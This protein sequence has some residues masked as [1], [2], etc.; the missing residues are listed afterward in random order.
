M[1][2]RNVLRVNRTESLSGSGSFSDSRLECSPRLV[3]PLSDER[4]SETQGARTPT[5][6]D[7]RFPRSHP[8]PPGT[9]GGREGSSREVR[10]VPLVL[11]SDRRDEPAQGRRAQ[12]GAGGVRRGFAG[13][14]F[15]ASRWTRSS[16]GRAI[17]PDLSGSVGARGGDAAPPP[18]TEGRHRTR[19][20]LCK[21]N[22]ARGPYP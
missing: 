5:G 22:Q 3:L 13:S 19:R 15:N 20:P 1:Y 17:R 18:R 2:P 10:R 8:F 14:R 16:R 4:D 11:R 12:A 21:S 9:M 7:V 6:P